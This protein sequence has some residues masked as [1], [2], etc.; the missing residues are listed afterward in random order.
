[1]LVIVKILNTCYMKKNK[2]SNELVGLILVVIRVFGRLSLVM[3][4][5]CLWYSWEMDYFI[6][7]F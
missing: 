6:Y 7:S 5:G 3:I 1:M 4:L 2:R